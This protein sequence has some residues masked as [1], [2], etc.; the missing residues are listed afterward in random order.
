MESS[1]MMNGM[2]ALTDQGVVKPPDDAEVQAAEG[3][4]V[5]LPDH[6]AEAWA[7]VLIDIHEKRK[8]MAADE[9]ANTEPESPSHAQ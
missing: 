6:I 4:P 7:G 8:R 3:G 5:V 2:E 9:A 1:S